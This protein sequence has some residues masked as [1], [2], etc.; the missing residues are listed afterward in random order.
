MVVAM[1]EEA[2]A[3]HGNIGRDYWMGGVK[4]SDGSWKWLNGDP[5]DYTNWCTDCPD[6]GA[7]GADLS[8]L[9]KDGYPGTLDTFYWAREGC[10]SSSTDNGVICE[11]NMDK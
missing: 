8:Q 7:E 5:M 3:I 11:I 4:I 2:L 1:A 10:I 6:T 9:L